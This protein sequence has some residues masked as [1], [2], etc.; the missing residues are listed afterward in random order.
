MNVVMNDGGA[1]IEVQGTG[2][3]GTF[4]PEQLASLTDLAVRGIAELTELQR[5][6]LA[7]A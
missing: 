6:A 3:G 2:E 1:F 7:E 4:S 5:K